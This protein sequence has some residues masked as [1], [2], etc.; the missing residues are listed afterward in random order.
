MKADRART[1]TGPKRSSIIGTVT[2]ILAATVLLAGCMEVNLGVDLRGGD[3]SV[4][5]FEL[6]VPEPLVQLVEATGQPLDEKSVQRD[7]LAGIPRRARDRVDV[8]VEPADGGKRLSLRIRFDSID[9]LNAMMTD[10]SD[11]GPLFTSFDLRRETDRWV[12]EGTPADLTAGVGAVPADAELQDG[13]ATL[14]SLLPDPDI[15]FSI[16][17]TGDVT[18]SN[19]DEVRGRSAKWRIDA[20]DLRSFT[21]E[22]EIGG[23]VSSLRIGVLVAV[24]VAVV[25]GGL[26]L[27]RRRRSSSGSDLSDLS[28]H[29]RSSSG[30]GPGASGGFGGMGRPGPSTQPGRSAWAEPAS[31]WGAPTPPPGPLSAPSPVWPQS[32]PQPPSPESSPTPPLSQPSNPTGHDSSNGVPVVPE[33]PDWYPDPW[34][35]AQWRWYDGTEWTSH[36]G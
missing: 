1:I 9:E 17:F 27:V 15:W 4:L 21:A 14:G 16:D 22:A 30:A 28:N 18:E 26:M 32:P 2:L 3:S 19:A 12:F 24:L 20:S 8:S 25:A 23:G 13:G 5:L 31:S 33:G 10:D 11:R 35:E 34:G 6:V 29:G 36:T 7:Y